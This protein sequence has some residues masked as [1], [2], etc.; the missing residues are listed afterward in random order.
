MVAQNEERAIVI[1][2]EDK[3]ERTF[4]YIDLPDLPAGG[5]VHEDLSVRDVHFSVRAGNHAFATALGEWLQVG[6]LPSGCTSPLYVRS[7]DSLLT[8]VRFPGVALMK[9]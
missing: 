2:P 4:R 3:L 7:S 8:Y 5:V 6:E 1:A 9:A